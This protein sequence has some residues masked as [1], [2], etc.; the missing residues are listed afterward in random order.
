MFWFKDKDGNDCPLVVQAWSTAAGDWYTKTFDTKKEFEDYLDAQFKDEPQ[1][2]KLKNTWKWKETGQAYESTVCKPN[3]EGGRY[4]NFT[5]GSIQQKR[6]RDTEKDRI[7]NGVIYDDIYVPPFYYWYLNFCPIYDDFL[8]KKRLPD[9][10]DGD[11][12]Y[13]QYVMRAIL[14]GKHVGGVKGRQKGY[15]Y[16]HMAILYWSYSWF[17]NSINTIGAYDEKLVKKSWRFLEG[18]RAHINKNTTWIRGPQIPKTLEWHET[19][20]DEVGQPQGLQSK[21]AGVTFKQKADNDVG[22]ATTFFNYEEP[23]V[24]PTILETLE[25]VRPSLEKGSETTGTIIACGSVGQLDDAEG[26]KTIFYQPEENNFLAVKNVWD[27][28]NISE[29]CCIFISEAYNMIGKDVHPIYKDTRDGYSGKPF[30][31]KDGNSDVE[32]AISWIAKNQELI[33]K[34]SKSAERKQLQ[35]SQKCISPEQAFASR[36][37]SEWPI[38]QIKRQQERILLKYKENKWDFVPLKGL[39]EE[40]KDGKPVLNTKD[41]PPEHEYPIKP[42]W[43]DKRG[44]W[45]LYAPIPENPENY[46]YYACVDAIEVDVTET[47]KSIASVDIFQAPIRIEDEKGK[48]LRVEGDKLV[49][50]YRGRFDTA[51]QTNEQI[52]LGI[53]AFNAW[54][55]PERNKPNF[56]NY[57]REMG[58]AERYLAKEGDVP[59]F[60]DLNFKNGSSVNNSKFGFHKGDN[61]EIWTLF[62]ATTKEYML[63]EYGRNTITKKNPD[64]EEYDETIKVFTGIDRIDDYWLLEEFKEYQEVKGKIKGNYD[65]LV[66][67]MGALFICKVYQQNRILKKRTE[68]TNKEKQEPVYRPPRQVSL[69]GGGIRTGYNNP[70]KPPRSMLG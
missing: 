15:S 43:E 54:V 13:M 32:L 3:F 42:D 33:R 28:K 65:R 67:F 29:K 60:K 62:K 4:H 5:K 34:S 12:W 25:F 51:R 23:G 59:L 11:L 10:W 16:K 57:M 6:W 49:A 50:T 39:F 19:Q 30:F 18:Y 46:M 52:W 44:V 48:F 14:K 58:R 36:S 40:D 63:A 55:Y 41:L 68:V 7:L 2:Y 21:L 45:T 26:I 64:G 27:T 35:L 61:T 56:I 70:R 47:S 1:F 37:V 9:V 31:D 24:S 20:M 53:K 17:E 66:S 69:I 22:G 8:K 38:E